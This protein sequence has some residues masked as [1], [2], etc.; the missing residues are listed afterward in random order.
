MKHVAGNIGQTEIASA[1]PIRQLG[2]VDPEQIQDR[3]VNVMDVDLR[4]RR[5]L[6]PEIVGLSV[7]G[8]ALDGAA[9]QPHG[10]SIWIVIAAALH[11]TATA[12]ADFTQR[13][14]A[15]F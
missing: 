2:V 15:K 12:A 11:T 6:E 7:N 14:T 1:I 10:E 13:S 9:S 4:L 5:R 3:R 8:S